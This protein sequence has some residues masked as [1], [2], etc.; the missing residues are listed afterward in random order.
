MSTVFSPT[1]ASLGPTAS[2]AN[3]RPVLRSRLDGVRGLSTLLMA[4]AVAALVVLAERL[5]GGWAE[6]HQ[7]LAWVALWLLILTGTAAVSA[8]ARGL[9][10]RVRHALQDSAAAI[11]EARAEVRLWEAARADHRVM[12]ECVQAR[13]RDLDDDAGLAAAW[14]RFPEHLH[15]GRGNATHL[16][17]C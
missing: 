1:P 6:Q 7:F 4:A 16:R 13:Q 2:F 11:A 17:H 8:P 5:M 12:A 14:G 15:D 9:A 10:R 3:P